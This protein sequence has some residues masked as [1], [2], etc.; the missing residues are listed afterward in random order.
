LY[1]TDVLIYAK[2]VFMTSGH[3]HFNSWKL[4]VILINVKPQTFTMDNL[5]LPSC[6]VVA[7]VYIYQFLLHLL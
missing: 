3:S 1:H 7:I 5:H 6:I 2:T 4:P